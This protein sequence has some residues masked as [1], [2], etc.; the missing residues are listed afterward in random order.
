MN[1]PQGMS[2]VIKHALGFRSRCVFHVFANRANSGDWLSARA[3]RS[4]L[5][6]RYCVELLCD[7]EYIR[8]TLAVLRFATSDDL[9]VIGGGGLIK[10]TFAPLW[11]GIAGLNPSIPVVLWGIGACVHKR[12]G[13]PLPIADVTAVARR[14]RMVSLRDD[15]SR[16]YLRELNPDPALACPSLSAVITHCRKTE[17][18]RSAPS[19]LKDGLLHVI[20]DR[21][22]SGAVKEEMT[23]AAREMA[24]RWGLS[25]RETD[26]MIPDGDERELTRLLDRYARASIVVSSRLHGC[27]MGIGAGCKVLAVSGD[28]KIESFMSAAG[29]ADWVL[30]GQDA[31]PISSKL[32]AVAEQPSIGPFLDFA[33]KAT[34]DLAD[35][36]RRMAPHLFYA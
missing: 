12:G 7:R 17:L 22:V 15:L 36:I 18:M 28:L 34:L 11:K 27:I 19:P 2:F 9:I 29:L 4:L 3:I 1:L 25:Y 16:D 31:G 32:K 23:S 24:L 35:R 6:P 13:A 10:D 5:K 21:L 26:N 33:E 30:E 20:H 8:Q 14:A